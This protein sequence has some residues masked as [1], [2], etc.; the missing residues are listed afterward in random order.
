MKLACTLGVRAIRG[1]GLVPW[2]SKFI[3][4][5]IRDWLRPPSHFMT[6]GWMSL[7]GC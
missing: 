3:I 4:L 7:S 5:G 2:G 1:L 6:T